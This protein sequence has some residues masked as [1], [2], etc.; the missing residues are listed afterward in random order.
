MKRVLLVCAVVLGIGVAPARADG[1]E[2]SSVTP[3][4]E[5]ELDAIAAHRVN[6]PRA[7][8]ALAHV[9]RAMYVAARAGGRRRA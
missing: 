5:L 3:W 7:S 1:A 8:R 2:T 9:S 6:P 4:I